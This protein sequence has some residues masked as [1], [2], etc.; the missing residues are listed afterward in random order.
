[1]FK[2]KHD[3]QASGAPARGLPV[4]SNGQTQR[5]DTAPLDVQAAPEE[6]AQRLQ[7][8]QHRTPYERE[9]QTTT[10]PQ[11]ENPGVSIDTKPRSSQTTQTHSEPGGE[12]DKAIQTV[13][14]PTNSGQSSTKAPRAFGSDILKFE[15]THETK[16]LSPTN[17]GQSSTKA[18]RAFGSD[19]LKFE[20]TL[21]KQRP[22]IYYPWTCALQSRQT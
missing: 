16:E 6:L 22:G 13:T 1:M 5:M 21:S 14:S 11:A 3:P 17:P 7:V 4:Q 15:L 12:K 19:I 10:S 2:N 8:S 18:P 20:L 9:S